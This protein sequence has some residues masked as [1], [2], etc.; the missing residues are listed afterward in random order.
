MNL[1][2]AANLSESECNVLFV[3]VLLINTVVFGLENRA[4][5]RDTG[6]HRVTRS[7]L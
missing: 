5:Y 6:F 3:T 7:P 2:D 4:V 1:I